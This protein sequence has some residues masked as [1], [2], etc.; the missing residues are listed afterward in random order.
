MC[1]RLPGSPKGSV[2]GLILNLSNWRITLPVYTKPCLGP[3]V[4]EEKPVFKG[5]MYHSCPH[6]PIPVAL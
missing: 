2:P 4:P 3:T 6:Q 1:S 5:H